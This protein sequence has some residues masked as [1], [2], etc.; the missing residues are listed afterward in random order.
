[1]TRSTTYQFKVVRD[2]LLGEGNSKDPF[3]FYSDLHSP[4]SISPSKTEFIIQVK[5]RDSNRK[6]DAQDRFV[7]IDK[8]GQKTFL[9]S[10]DAL[11]LL[12]YYVDPDLLKSKALGV[13]VSRS[14]TESSHDFD[15]VASLEGV[16]QF[17]TQDLK[18]IRDLHFPFWE[19]DGHLDLDI[20]EGVRI[21]TEEENKQWTGIG[22][23]GI[24]WNGRYF[25]KR[26]L[27]EKGAV[28]ASFVTIEHLAGP[29]FI[30]QTYTTNFFSMIAGSFGK[31]NQ[32]EG[33]IQAGPLLS[34]GDTTTHE[35]RRMINI[36][37]AKARANL[38]KDH[39]YWTI[40]GPIVTAACFADPFFRKFWPA[41]WRAPRL[42]VVY[43]Y[44]ASQFSRA[45]PFVGRSPFG[46]GAAAL[47]GYGIYEL[48]SLWFDIYGNMP[49]GSTENRAFSL[50]ATVLTQAALYSRAA[51]EMEVITGFSRLTYSNLQG[52]K[53]VNLLLRPAFESS[54]INFFGLK[55]PFPKPYLRAE[56]TE[57]VNAASLLERT[58]HAELA[59]IEMG[60]GEATH[61]ANLLERR[62]ALLEKFAKGDALAAE[63]LGLA[64]TSRLLATEALTGEELV[65]AESFLV[66]SR[67]KMV[68]LPLLRASIWLGVGVGFC[69]L[70][71]IFDDKNNPREF[72]RKHF[73]R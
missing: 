13:I 34:N 43:N 23:V 20:L 26:V 59:N 58:G 10:Q 40:T 1:M 53:K 25:M 60:V 48:S 18:E 67:M 3:R 68:G 33:I 49:Q 6:I 27:G 8:E 42:G 54:R 19:V 51:R 11:K 12:N 22:G 50:G 71:G 69:Y 39:L 73:G 31:N 14:E 44:F 66:R 55:F 61:T 21:Y 37:T 63:R 47:S 72:I 29:H 30:W 57:S 56:W 4:P 28:A 52:L 46:L 65:A 62:A 32:A 17:S 9:D 7:L 35:T 15:R 45:I 41:P 5:D 16:K 38:S 36:E 2:S 24:F 70:T 64:T